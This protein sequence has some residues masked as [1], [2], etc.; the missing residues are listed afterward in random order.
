MHDLRDYNT[1]TARQLTAAI[2]Q[3]N[4]NTASKDDDPPGIA[5][6]TTTPAW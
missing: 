3:L 6:Q 2:G 1:L 4:H 5:G